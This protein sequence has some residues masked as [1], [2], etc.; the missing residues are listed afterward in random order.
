MEG[1]SATLGRPLRA[2]DLDLV[3]AWGGEGYARFLLQ[4]R[5]PPIYRGEELRRQRSSFRRNEE[6]RSHRPAEQHPNLRPRARPA[7]NAGRQ[8]AQDSA[9]RARDV[10]CGPPMALPV[11]E[12]G[13]RLL[14]PDA[15]LPPRF[16]AVLCHSSPA[17]R[18]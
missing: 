3:P 15:L 8:R 17:A 16:T 13:L 12:S 14:P 7:A 5:V 6:L 4:Q 2:R 18:V 1:L 10:R 11:E 9:Q